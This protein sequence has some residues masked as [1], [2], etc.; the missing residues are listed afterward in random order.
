[1]KDGYQAENDCEGSWIERYYLGYGILSAVGHKKP[2][3]RGH[4]LNRLLE[5]PADH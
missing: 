2:V 4:V 1:M 5:W 3:R